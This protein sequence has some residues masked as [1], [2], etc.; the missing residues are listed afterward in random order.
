[1]RLAKVDDPLALLFP[2]A[3]ALCGE[4]RQ[5][6]E[7]CDPCC[8]D[9]PWIRHGCSLC[10]R[11]L[12][13]DAAPGPCGNCRWPASALS[14]V[15][16]GL[17]YEYPVD[18]LVAGCKY[19]GRIE[20]GQVL[21]ELLAARLACAAREPGWQ[22]PDLLLPVPLHPAREA[23]RGFN[24]A[25]EIARVL[26]RRLGIPVAR[27]LARRLRATPEQAALG[28]KARA[29]NL[30]GAFAAG[31]GCAGKRIALVDDVITTGATAVAVAEAARAAGA[32]EV[33]CW[34]VA[35]TW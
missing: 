25:A 19:R 32:E 6:R 31:D 22:A 26:K 7:I 34:V 10:G 15:I 23:S 8:D 30:R 24:Q 16:A 28:A 9:L 12:P 5:Q 2:P 4:P 1:M 35:L 27:R 33:Q 21:G 11:P 3:C 14:R 17:V 18:R 20:L 29:A 13:P